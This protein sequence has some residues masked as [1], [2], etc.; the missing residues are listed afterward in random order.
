MKV[1]GTQ[2]RNT[3]IEEKEVISMNE[4]SVFYLGSNGK[5]Q[6]EGRSTNYTS[7]FETKQEAINSL[8]ATTTNQ[9][10]QVKEELVSLENKLK[11]INAIQ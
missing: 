1:Y 10:Q 4:K 2:K 7:W 3:K 11:E 8:R 5:Q 6:R 9:I